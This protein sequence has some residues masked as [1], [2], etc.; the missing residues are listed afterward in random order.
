L[1]KERTKGVPSDETVGIPFVVGKEVIWNHL[2]LE[3]LNKWKTCKGC[4]QF[5]N[6]T[7]EPLP[8]RTKELHAISRQ[9]LT[10]AVELL[11]G[12]TTVHIFKLGLTQQQDCRLCGDKKD[13]V[14]ILSHRLA[15]ACK[16]Q[17]NLGHMFWSPRI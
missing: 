2:R 1:A 8:S 10:V 17:R 9:K 7:Y 4:R 5:K 16:R 11:A 12:H 3:H 14:H 6:L 13:S 15:L